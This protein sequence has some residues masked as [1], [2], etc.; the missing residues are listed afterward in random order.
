MVPGLGLTVMSLAKL[1]FSME[2]HQ[3]MFANSSSHAIQLDLQTMAVS[4]TCMDREKLRH[5]D[6]NLTM[7]ETQW[8]TF[9]ASQNNYC[10]AL[11]MLYSL[12]KKQPAR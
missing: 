7:T 11:S 6:E 3:L 2:I 12:I 4:V 10:G 5:L 1:T 9:V 8:Q